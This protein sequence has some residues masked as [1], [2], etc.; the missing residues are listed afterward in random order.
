MP[1]GAGSLTLGELLTGVAATAVV[2]AALGVSAPVGALLGVTLGLAW[3]RA[4]AVRRGGA[5]RG[6]VPTFRRALLA[7]LDSLVCAL[8]IVPPALG[9]ALLA[10]VPGAFV[11]EVVLALAGSGGRPVVPGCAAGAS[12]AAGLGV[13][14]LLA[15]GL[16]PGRDGTVPWRSHASCFFWIDDEPPPEG[17]SHDE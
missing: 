9:A 13:V 1:R 3:H 14:L 2:L 8:L 12:L 4:R 16:W 6:H 15:R 10:I 5:R 11:G 17:P 7:W